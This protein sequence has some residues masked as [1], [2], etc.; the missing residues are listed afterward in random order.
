MRLSRVLILAAWLLA[1]SAFPQGRLA[2]LSAVRKIPAV[3]VPDVQASV[4]REAYVGTWKNGT[5]VSK[6]LFWRILVHQGI[7]DKRKV[8]AVFTRAERVDTAG[9]TWVTSL[10]GPNVKLCK[11]AVGLKLVVRMGLV[12]HVVDL[13]T[14]EDPLVASVNFLQGK[15]GAVSHRDVK[16]DAAGVRSWI[17]S[18]CGSSCLS[19]LKMVGKKSALSTDYKLSI[20]KI[21]QVRDHDMRLWLRDGGKP[22][23]FVYSEKR[24][25][26]DPLAAVPKE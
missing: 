13:T 21:E 22:Y 25:K 1:V 17:A 19:F 18:P 14:P 3:S 24:W 6:G 12:I 5:K 4:T 7:A 8:Y 9:A 20:E 26:M 2:G 11:T 15:Y 16:P 10:G 23:Q